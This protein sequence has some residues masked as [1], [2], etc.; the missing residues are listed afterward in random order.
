MSGRGDHERLRQAFQSFFTAENMSGMV[1][2]LCQEMQGIC[3]HVRSQAQASSDGAAQVNMVDLAVAG[4]DGVVRKV[5]A[6]YAGDSSAAN[7][8]WPCWRS[9]PLTCWAPIA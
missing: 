7:T 4:M 1:A 6:L 2:Q 9:C 3:D 8:C 5:R